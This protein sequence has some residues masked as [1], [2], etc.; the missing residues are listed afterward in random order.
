[1]NGKPVAR[2]I[3]GFALLAILVLPVVPT[4]SAKV[5]VHVRAVTWDGRIL[6]DRTV[7]AGTATVRTSGKATC[8]GGSP[9]SG[10]KRVPGATA[11][12]ALQQAQAARKPHRPLLISDAFDFGLGVCGVGDAVAEGEQWWELTHNH[13]PSTLGGEGTRLRKNDSVLWYLAKSYNLPSP[14]ELYLEAPGKV[15]K[16][17][18]FKVRV[19]AFDDQGRSRPVAGAKL[20]VAGTGRTDSRGYAR[21]SIGKKTRFVARADGLIVSNRVVVR[22]RR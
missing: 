10:S 17:K 9:G 22:I 7:R 4:A 6:L 8:L 3:L 20:S 11:L 21:V 16:K 1:M 2:L 13:Q 14:D 18:S 12:G 19:L 15:R 5:P